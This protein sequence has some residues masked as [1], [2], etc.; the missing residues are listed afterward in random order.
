MACIHSNA[1]CQAKLLG[2][3]RESVTL[4][5]KLKTLGA[6]SRKAGATHAQK[7]AAA[8][9]AKAEVHKAAQVMAMERKQ[10]EAAAKDYALAKQVL[11]VEK[12][13]LKTIKT[14][15]E[16]PAHKTE[17][18]DLKEYQA[19][20][21][22]HMHALAKYRGASSAA[23]HA[24]IVY[25]KSVK[26][27]CDTQA[28][29]AELVRQI[30][31]GHLKK[32]DCKATSA[33]GLQLGRSG[34]LRK[35]ALVQSSVSLPK[36][37]TLTFDITLKGRVGNW[38]SVFHFTKGGNCCGYG[39][40]IPAMW[41]RPNSNSF[42]VVDGTKRNGNANNVQGTLAYNKKYS[43]K[44]VASANSFDTY[45]N[46]KHTGRLSRGGVTREALRGV[47]MYMTDPWY[48][49]ANAVVSKITLTPN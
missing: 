40:R 22:A 11:T 15:T 21:I 26:A 31:Y 9:A 43:V 3:M 33:H 18:K 36:A 20:K 35:G 16:P 17:N 47:K 32:T 39:S 1:K 2:I 48:T 49:A 23:A 29:H 41:L 30:G 28:R 45:L 34:K 38:G 10:Y 46:G 7:V 25:K 19:A 24:E 44:M 12:K 6:A 14:S 13:V 5:A 8:K 27:H 42:I 37:Y 4:E